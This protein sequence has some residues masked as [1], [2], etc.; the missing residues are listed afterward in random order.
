M[1]A[2]LA[3]NWRGG[4]LPAIEAELKDISLSD[5]GTLRITVPEDVEMDLAGAWQLREWLK[6]AEKDGLSVEFSGT[7]PGQ[8][9]LIDSTIA[10]KRTM[11]AFSSESEFQPVNRLGRQVFVQGR[12]RA[13]DGVPEPE[14]PGM[15]GGTGAHRQT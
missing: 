11:P 4:D 5:A 12:L 15:A 8:L 6:S 3:G 1:E 9:E 7:E 13:R 2:E 14:R 10:H